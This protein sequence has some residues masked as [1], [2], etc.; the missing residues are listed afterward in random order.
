MKEVYGLRRVEAPELALA[1]PAVQ[2]ALCE[3]PESW[4]D[5]QT[6]KS[7]AER[8]SAGALQLW[9]LVDGD[10]VVR[11][12]FMTRVFDYPQG[13]VLQIVWAYGSDAA[14]CV[15]SMPTLERLAASLGCFR[16][17]IVPGRTGWRKL[18]QEQGYVKAYEVLKKD[19]T[20]T[21]TLQ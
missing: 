8:L 16:L 11:F 10:F 5:T 21:G 9:T 6:L 4:S 12:L 3:A 7:I 18:L 13:R 2:R 14:H 15:L 19:L 20:N 1:W 17:E